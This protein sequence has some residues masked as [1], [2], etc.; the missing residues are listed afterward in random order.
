MLETLNT[1]TTVAGTGL[2][3]SPTT[4]S[5]S[6]VKKVKNPET[7]EEE[8]DLSGFKFGTGLTAAT[9]TTVVPTIQDMEYQRVINDARSEMAIVEC[10]TEEE[11]FAALRELDKMLEL[12]T[13]FEDEATDTLGEYGDA[14]KPYT[15]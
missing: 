14:K 15:K 12:S 4:T 1:T 11:Q 8:W 13:M 3:A 7:K 9:T 10:A 6:G 2:I 5:A